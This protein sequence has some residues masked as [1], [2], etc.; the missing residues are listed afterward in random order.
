[1]S[2]KRPFVQWTI[3]YVAKGLA[4]GSITK[5]EAQE[6]VDAFGDGLTVAEVMGRLR[7]PPDPEETASNAYHDHPSHPSSCERFREHYRRECPCE[8]WWPDET[9]EEASKRRAR[10]GEWLEE[11]L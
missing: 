1:M 3:V 7:L 9:A 6:F 5:A 10:L 11:E 4:N 2:K 8:Q